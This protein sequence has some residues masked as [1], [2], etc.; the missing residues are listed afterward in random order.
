MTLEK[1]SRPYMADSVD[2]HV[3]IFTRDLKLSSSRRYEPD[4]E[5]TPEALIETLTEHGLGKALIVQPSFLGT[6]NTYLLDALAR[7]P[8]RFRGVAVIDPSADRETMQQLAEGGVVGV[9]LNA[10]GRPAPDL[11]SVTYRRFT[12]LLAE[13]DLFLEIQAEGSQWN[14]MASILSDL[15]CDLVID[16]F[17]RT[18][19]SHESGGFDTLLAIAQRKDIWFKFSAPYRFGSQEGK[20]CAGVLVDTVGTERIVW[21]SD[22]PWTQFEGRHTYADCLNW[23]SD[24]VAADDIQ[25]VL[26]KNAA[27]LLRFT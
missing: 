19:V 1:I 6:D 20:T 4:Y 9:R 5:A 24:W 3:H 10:I 18:P 23:L 21:G 15:P 17:G 16:H 2:C 26:T 14:D 13:L 8:S 7:Y 12:R 25:N 11:G 22:W 27:K